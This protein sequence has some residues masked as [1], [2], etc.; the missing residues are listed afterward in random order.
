MRIGH[1]LLCLH[2]REGGQEVR[3]AGLYSLPQI[4]TICAVSG[5]YIQVLMETI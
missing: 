4:T 2:L 1:V 5:L 3:N